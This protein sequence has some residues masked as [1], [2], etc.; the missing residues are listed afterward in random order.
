MVDSCGPLASIFALVCGGLDT[1][2]EDELT[3]SEE[4]SSEDVSSESELDS[5][6]EE[7]TDDVLE[8]IGVCDAC[9]LSLFLRDGSLRDSC[10]ECESVQPDDL[11]FLFTVEFSSTG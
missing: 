2:D 3:Q 10:L 5:E 11:F 4:S 6:S 1:L 9:R 7:D 8:D